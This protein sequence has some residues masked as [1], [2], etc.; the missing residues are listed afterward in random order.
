MINE[1][2]INSIQAGLIDSSLSSND[3]FRP[4]LLVNKQPE[5]KVINYIRKELEHCEEFMFSVAFITDGGLALLKHTLKEL[6]ELGIKGKIMTADYLSFNNPDMFYNLMKL[7]NVEI[8]INNNESFH[9][10]GYFFKKKNEYTFIVGSANLT[11]RAL[12]KN[13]E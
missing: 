5:V 12:T 1:E 10:K 11:E 13:T 9:A 2:L 8:K 3:D 7:P 4:Q 6:N